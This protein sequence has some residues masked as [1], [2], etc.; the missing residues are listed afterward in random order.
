MQIP[1]EANT[2]LYLLNNIFEDITASIIIS[3][4]RFLMEIDQPRA[5]AFV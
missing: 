1:V 2:L 4:P 3:P 5:H